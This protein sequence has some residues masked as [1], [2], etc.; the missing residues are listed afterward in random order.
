VLNDDDIKLPAHYEVV[1]DLPGIKLN[2]FP[3]GINADCVNVETLK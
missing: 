3:N 1:A 2:D